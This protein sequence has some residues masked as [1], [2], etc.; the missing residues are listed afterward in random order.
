MQISGSILKIY[1]WPRYDIALTCS[2]I[3]NITGKR[4]SVV[5]KMMC[6]L[7]SRWAFFW[8]NVDKIGKTRS[9]LG[10]EDPLE[11]EM[12]THS[13]IHA[14]KI[15]WT[16]EPGGPQSMG[17]QRVGHDWATSLSLSDKIIWAVVSGNKAESGG[18]SFGPYAQT[19][20]N[21]AKLITTVHHRP[22]SP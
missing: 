20:S 6:C 8:D 7:Q 10:W 1:F 2:R 12:A 19:D 16:E 3:F 11:K 18:K 13:S 5:V 17:L 15:P 22:T 14:W 21:I 4:P 9:S